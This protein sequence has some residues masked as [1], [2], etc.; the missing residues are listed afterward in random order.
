MVGGDD[1][2][3]Q[4]DYYLYEMLETAGNIVDTNSSRSMGLPASDSGTIDFSGP[5]AVTA[6]LDGDEDLTGYANLAANAT[7]LTSTT[8]MLT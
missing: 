2:V 5:R 1:P 7:A 6:V 3:A 4:V 8:S